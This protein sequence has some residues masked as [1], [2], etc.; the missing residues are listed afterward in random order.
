LRV[1]KRCVTEFQ[2]K[3]IHVAA[4]LSQQ[5]AEKALK[6]FILSR[7]AIPPKIHDL[8]VLCGICATYDTLFQDLSEACG[9]LTPFAVGARY[10]DEI[11]ITDS[12]AEFAIEKADMIHGFCSERIL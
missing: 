5:A 4:S 9:M 11:E 1:A 10:P 3:E 8:T 6:A 12:Q 2:P 7:D